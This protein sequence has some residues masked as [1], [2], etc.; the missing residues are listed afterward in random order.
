MDDIA[1]L[2]DFKL[3]LKSWRNDFISLDFNYIAAAKIIYLDLGL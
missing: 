2:G 3:V 1:K